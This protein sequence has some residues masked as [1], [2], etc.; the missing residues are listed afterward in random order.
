MVG[1]ILKSK[2]EKGVDILGKNLE[3]GSKVVGAAPVTQRGSSRPR[4]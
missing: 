2:V 3:G 4:K 1:E